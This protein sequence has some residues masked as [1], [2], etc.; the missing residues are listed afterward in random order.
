MQS[1][2]GDVTAKVNDSVNEKVNKIVED[3]G[4]KLEVM[5]QEKQSIVN[6]KLNKVDSSIK[7]CCVVC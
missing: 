2:M 7:D 6:E 3:V 1:K 5:V 4:E